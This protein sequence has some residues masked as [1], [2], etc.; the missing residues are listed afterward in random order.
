VTAI[1]LRVNGRLMSAMVEPRLHLADFLREHCLLTGTHLGCEHGVCGACTV[2][3]DGRPVRSCITLAVAADGASVDTIE[4][5][6]NDPIMTRLRD[7]FTSEHALQCGYCTPGMLITARDIVQRLPGAD[8]ARVRVELS[9]NLCRCTGYA[10]IVRAVCRALAE[11]IPAGASEPKAPLPARP[12]L[13]ILEAGAT[14]DVP[15]EL[16]PA[17]APHRGAAVLSHVVKIAAGRTAVWAAIKDPNLL[18]A[19]A[20]GAE[21]TA[22][23]PPNHVAGRIAV[24]LG[25]M[26]AYFNGVATLSYD[27]ERWS[28]TV[29][30]HGDDRATGT[31][32]HFTAKYR[33]DEEG[34]DASVVELSLDYGLR[35]LLA[36]VGRADV[37]KVFATEL[38]QDVARNLE[39]RLAGLPPT[40]R[41]PLGVGRF[42]LKLVSAHVTRLLQRVKPQGRD[43]R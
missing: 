6:E 20:P 40:T 42:L 38:I 30:G 32:L 7:A 18:A 39:A 19:C 34:P 1:S 43:G 17:K 28:G 27:D 33:I 37:I 29:E 25:P 9:G 22:F 4:G 12:Y 41:R 2:L 16:P 11:V 26:R 13:A 5:L 3:L 21:L 35:G 23:T 15:K 24:A 14:K 31:R 36:Q 8:A 10:G